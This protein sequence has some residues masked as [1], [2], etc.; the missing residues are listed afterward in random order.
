MS[1]SASPAIVVLAAGH[2]L[3]WGVLQVSVANLLVILVMVVLFVAALLIP[4][5]SATASRPA[6]RSSRDGA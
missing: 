3:Q 5:P 4:F 1:V 6:A 2:Y